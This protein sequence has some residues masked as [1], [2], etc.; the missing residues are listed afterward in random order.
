MDNILDI[1]YEYSTKCKI[2]D[3]SAIE[4]IIN[5]GKNELSLS[6][7]NHVEKRISIKRTPLAVYN[8]FSETIAIYPIAISRFFRNSKYKSKLILESELNAVETCFRKNLIIIHMILHEL[9]H[10]NQF[11]N[12][13]TPSLEMRLVDL[14]LKYL[15]DMEDKDD[16]FY[17]N[18]NKAKEAV[19]RN[20]NYDKLYDIS[21]LERMANINAFTKVVELTKKIGNDRLEELHSD[22]FLSLCMREYSCETDSPTLRFF[23]GIKRNSRA[24]SLIKEYNLT[25]E[26]RIKY[27]LSLTSEEYNR[28]IK[29]IKSKRR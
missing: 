10:A 8:V 29:L 13:D 6:N 4:N 5:T 25:Y 16:D 18:P 19:I 17:S 22:L 15:F 27:G 9:E 12:Y 21:F 28:N 11:S 2:L 7:V 24:N 3:N 23:K 1:L 26:D 14:E 20:K